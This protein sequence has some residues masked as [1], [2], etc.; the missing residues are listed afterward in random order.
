[1][2]NNKMYVHEIKW[3]KRCPENTRLGDADYV[4]SYIDSLD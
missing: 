3:Q 4:Q 1:M 2:K